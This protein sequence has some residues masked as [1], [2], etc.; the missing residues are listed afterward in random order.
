M[1]SRGL[2]IFFGVGIVIVVLALGLH[3]VLRHYN[4]P[5]GAEYD[6]LNVFAATF[7]STILTF[8]IGALLFD[9]QVEKTEAKKHEQYR[10]LL[11]TELTAILE[12]LDHA[13]AMRV[14]LSDG[15]AAKVV[16]THLQPMVVEEA[17]RD[18]FF[19]PDQLERALRLA[20]N[21]HA[22]NAKVSYL[23]SVLSS[24]MKE[25]QDSGQ[26]VLQAIDEIEVTRYAIVTDARKLADIE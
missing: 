20:R 3:A 11:V 21:M 24:E 19:D 4:A 17:V 23:L 2:R 12:G 22:Y 9:Y 13:N 14:R 18:G 5:P 25:E 16:V 15:S 7:A 8:F 10:M 26:F 6:L 1:L